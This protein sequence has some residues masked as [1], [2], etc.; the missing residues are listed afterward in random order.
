MNNKVIIFV[1]SGIILFG[2]CF[3]VG[4]IINNRKNN[5][6]I[7]DNEDVISKVD[8]SDASQNQVEDKTQ[9]QEEK[10]E[11]IL[12]SSRIGVDIL[13]NF[14]ITNVYSYDFY[15][16]LDQEGLSDK[17]K[18]SWS[19][20]NIMQGSDYLYMLQYLD[21]SLYT[22]ISEANLNTVIDYTFY[23]SKNTKSGDL[24]YN[25]KFN[26]EMKRYEIPSIG[27]ANSDGVITVEVPY[28]ILE[29]ENGKY[30]VY[31][32]RIYMK[33]SIEENEKNIN[34]NVD[35]EE[36]FANIVTSIYYDKTLNNK[37][38]EINDEKLL[39]NLDGQREILSE[40][41]NLN[42][43][44]KESITKVKYTLVKEGS[45]YKISDYTKI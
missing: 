18:R 14:N 17:V 32:Y 40:Y 36:Q 45:Y 25:F 37:A 35:T 39:A 30:E 24:I 22:Y 28:E 27:V 6:K 33:Q 29:Y 1:I 41:I 42:K 19:F 38:C 2:L 10:V 16:L 11:K 34:E 9:N 4:Y 21:D 13:K 15:E 43:I 20:V 5:D 12:T 8:N 3:G 7:I 26:D 31:M 23:N 44:K